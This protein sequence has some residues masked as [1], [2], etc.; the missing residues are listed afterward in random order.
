MPTSAAAA[1]F[2][3]DAW[4][5][6]LVGA[7]HSVSHFFQLLLP[8]L[9]P[10]IK[11][12][13]GL[14]YVELGAL[15]ALFYVISGVGQALAGFV[16]DKVGARTVLF[17][18][19]TVLTASG[20]VV[21]G[22]SGY[23]GLAVGAAL[24]G[25]GNCV[26]HPVDFTLLN[27]RVSPSRLAHAF[28]VHGITGN[29]GYAAAPVFLVAIAQFSGSWRTAAFA[30]A[31]VGFVVLLIVWLGR[32]LLDD[33]AEAAAEASA[34]PSGSG[35]SLDFLKLP[36]VWACFA[37]FFIASLALGGIQNFAPAA[38]EQLYG[39]P[40]TL[41]ALAY[42]VFMLAS[43]GGMLIGGF[44]AA[45]TDNHD[46]LIAGCFTASGTLLILLGL[47]LAPAVSVLPIMALAGFGTGVAN[48]SRDLL[49]RTA[50]PKG[51]TG[52]VYG[53]VYSGLDA[54]M[55]TA[56]LICGV[57]M[58]LGQ[59]GWLFVTVGVC[60]FLA[61]ATAVSVGSGSRR[62]LQQGALEAGA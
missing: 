35:S 11:A 23:A 43:A 14:S 10:W 6:G 1:K 3:T 41:A 26:F 49:V 17:F 42:T 21:A 22:S 58:D 2:R 61:I 59:P 5:I 15:M 40:L 62:R 47:D 25:L 38:L 52:R 19:L 4:V 53:T 32:A 54:G 24:A 29:L 9:F 57:I 33:S 20:L 55:A 7:A 39:L 12:E 28:S 56:P 8:P 18:G 30:A 45:R 36:Q 46:R 13:L 51:A 31:G 44:A 60:Q 50:A 48:P 37:F 16:V 34:T 27:R